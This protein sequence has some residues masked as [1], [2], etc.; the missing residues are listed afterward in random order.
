MV[1]DSKTLILEAA[2]DAD[3]PA[4]VTL[5]NRA[6]RGSN[7]P[8]WTTEAGYIAGDRT[9]EP[10]LRAE[11][12]EKPQATLLT[13]RDRQ[14]TSLQG[15]VWVEPLGHDTWY[16]G[17]L[18]VDP[19]Q[20]SRGLGSALLS[21]AEQ[22]ILGRGGKRIRITVI[23]IR[24]PLIAW[25]LR[26]GYLQTGESKPFPYGDHRFGTPQRDDLNFLVLEKI[27]SRQQEKPP[28]PGSQLL[29]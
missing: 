7:P 12:A 15:C 29:A 18:A 23:N 17:S 5:M 8:G 24:E 13:L 11:L 10:L 3:L 4:L 21:A 9:T 28:A 1:P 14:E 22:W 16:L 20:Q 25:Y 19:Q 26:R 2:E 27:L 6:Y